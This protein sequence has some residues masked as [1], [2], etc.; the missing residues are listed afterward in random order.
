MIKMKLPTARQLVEQFIKENG[1]WTNV[2]GLN[3]FVEGRKVGICHLP[4]TYNREFRTLRQ[5]MDVKEVK[6]DHYMK[7]EVV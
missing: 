2:Q 6:Y 5:N 3:L 7:W 4:E 1:F